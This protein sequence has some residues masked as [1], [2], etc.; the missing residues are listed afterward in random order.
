MRYRASQQL[1]ERVSTGTQFGMCSERKWD[2]FQM[3]MERECSVRLFGSS[4]VFSS[5]H[6]S[7]LQKLTVFTANE[8][9]NIC[10]EG[11]NRQA[12]YATV[13]KFSFGR[14]NSI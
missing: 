3:Q 7:F 2:V 5:Y 8:D 13:C 9:E 14:T 4:T 11:L 12:G 1:K 10:L 6:Y